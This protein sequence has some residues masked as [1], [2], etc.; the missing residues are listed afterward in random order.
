MTQSELAERAGISLRTVQRVEAGTAPKGFTLKALAQTL[1]VPTAAL[2][3]HDNDTYSRAA[4]INTSTLLGLLL[5][6]GNLLLPGLLTYKTAIPEAKQLGKA[7]L[8]V[9]IIYTL[10]LS[11]LLIAAPFVQHALQTTFPLLLTVFFSM[12]ALNVVLILINGKALG[13]KQR[14]PLLLKNPI[15]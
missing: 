8:S 3:P 7:L 11:A 13:K 12:K 9:Q 10:L 15:F 6:F 1:G 5:P 14:P 2:L 4:L